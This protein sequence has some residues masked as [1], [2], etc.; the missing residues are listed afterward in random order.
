MEMV[1]KKEVPC[2]EVVELAT[3]YLEEA[4]LEPLRSL[5]EAHLEECDGCQ[6]YLEQLRQTVRFLRSY[7]E[8]CPPAA[9]DME[10]LSEI[11]RSWAATST[12]PERD[13]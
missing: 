1:N 5:L 2:R 9:V 13:K 8:A 4:L 11:F 7:G 3:D 12:T 6:E 10:K